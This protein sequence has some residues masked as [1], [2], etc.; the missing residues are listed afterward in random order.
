MLP[1]TVG[2]SLSGR[3]C[4]FFI[5]FWARARVTHNRLG[6][7]SGRGGQ[8][9]RTVLIGW[10]LRFC[11][12]SILHNYIAVGG[13]D[14]C[15][16]QIAPSH[17]FYSSAFWAFPHLFHC[18]RGVK[19]FPRNQLEQETVLLRE[20]S[21]RLFSNYYL[22]GIN[23]LLCVRCFCL[24][25]GLF[26][27]HIRNFKITNVWRIF[28]KSMFLGRFLSYSSGKKIKYEL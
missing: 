4:W 27:I 6:P 14:K 5:S 2:S 20:N 10:W 1:R 18:W 15:T 22:Y 19:L 13:R 7:I 16:L 9:Q 25:F 12:R 11:S 24:L 28:K 3:V 23:W 26:Y 17:H 21:I 8:T